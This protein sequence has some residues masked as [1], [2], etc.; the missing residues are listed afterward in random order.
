MSGLAPSAAAGLSSPR[1]AR[2]SRVCES[3]DDASLV[4]RLVALSE[5]GLP[6]MFDREAGRFAH[7]VERT[8][9]APE[10]RGHSHRY[11]SIV[12][13]GAR[14]LG[15][16]RQRALFGGESA[17][18][19]CGRQ[20]GALADSDDLGDTALAAWAAAELAHP[21]LPRALARLRALWSTARNPY[22]VETAWTLSALC[23]A[24]VDR[25]EAAGV[26]DALTAALFDDASLFPHWI[27]P[28]RAPRLRA[29][30]GCFADQVY[31]T[32]ALA[33]FHATFGDGESLVRATRCAETFCR[34]QGGAGQWWWHYDARHDQV[35]EGYPVYTV[36][37]DSMAPMALLDLEDAGGPA[38][39]E[40]IRRGLAWMVQAAEIDTCLIDDEH[41]VI[42][43]KVARREPG[44]L[45]RSARA[46]AT[47]VHHGFR[48]NALDA[49][50][51]PRTIDWESR[52]YHLGWVL[53]CWLGGLDLTESSAA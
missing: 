31:P 4:Q 42:W 45:V 24:R 44:K 36:H 10:R 43:R 32:Q 28:A 1:A 19:F 30:V 52:P 12:L 8:P 17:A 3:A 33:R 25:G 5:R 39:H 7:H 46:V 35:T 34:L 13:L 14:A 40:P 41:A 50:F 20:I 38:L 21:E 47:S 22:V 53:S 23:A 51:P 11:G 27:H 49:V 16:E 2:I 15:E 29:H 6:R 26:R 37:Q 48:A 9:G 18:E